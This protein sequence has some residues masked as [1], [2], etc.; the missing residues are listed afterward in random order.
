MTALYADDEILV[1]H[2]ILEP[3]EELAKEVHAHQSETIVNV[4]GKIWVDHS[5]GRQS[6]LMA[7]MHYAL[8][9]L[10]LTYIEAGVAHAVGNNSKSER[11]EYVAILRRVRDDG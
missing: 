7:S 9:N 4:R 8:G 1:G 5:V 11:A 6:I 3:G 10:R 2:V